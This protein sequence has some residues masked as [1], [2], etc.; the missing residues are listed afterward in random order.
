MKRLTEN[1]Q[2]VANFTSKAATELTDQI[3]DQRDSE[4]ENLRT[5][6]M[7]VLKATESEMTGRTKKG[8]SDT[9]IKLS[10]LLNQLT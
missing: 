1:L 4:F 9:V 2:R 5:E 8:K 10:E 7:E 6:I 3:I